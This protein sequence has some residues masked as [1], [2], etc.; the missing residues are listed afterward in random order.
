MGKR[1]VRVARLLRDIV[2]ELL[3]LSKI[4]AGRIEL[5]DAL[6][7]P[8]NVVEKTV[9]LLSWKA[10]T[11]GLKLTWK[12]DPN[13]PRNLVGDAGRLRQVLTNLAGNA[14]KFTTRGEVAI[15]VSLDQEPALLRFTV[16][17]TGP[18]IS[19]DGQARLFQRFEQLQAGEQNGTGLGLAICKELVQLMGGEIG[20]TSEEGM[21]STF[22]F[23][24]AFTNQST[25]QNLS[26]RVLI[27]GVTL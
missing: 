7:D 10:R 3:D 6:F 12:F 13:V 8:R 2:N 11:K 14:L 23:T 19:R 26:L 25:F 5:V 20:V 15:G 21:G 24:S 27:V 18:G 4:E 1:C 22:W 9:E 16:I 17:D